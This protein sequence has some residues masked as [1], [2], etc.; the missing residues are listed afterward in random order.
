[1]DSVAINS[2]RMRFETYDVAET[3]AQKVEEAQP[4]YKNLQ[5]GRVITLANLYSD[6]KIVE[7]MEYCVSVDICTAAEVTAY[8]IYRY[9]YCLRTQLF[10]RVILYDGICR[11]GSLIS[12][13]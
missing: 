1:M 3:F 12:A 6:E 9:D 11:L 2:F 13:R 5:L 7:A 4:R 10:R 8:L